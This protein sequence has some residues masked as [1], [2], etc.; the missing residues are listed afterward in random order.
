MT[1]LLLLDDT[2]GIAPLA[3]AHELGWVT[4]PLETVPGLTAQAAQRRPE[5]LLFA[6]VAEYPALQQG[7]TILL[8]LG[9]QESDLTG[10]YAERTF[11]LPNPVYYL[12]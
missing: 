5:A 10:G 4:L 8:S 11:K 9:D 12:P 1:P 2:P 6:P 7:Y 3:L